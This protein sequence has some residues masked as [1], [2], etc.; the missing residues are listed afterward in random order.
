M[1]RKPLN[2]N[3]LRNRCYD[4]VREDGNDFSDYEGYSG[5]GM[6]G[7]HSLFA[8]TTNVDPRSKLGLK[9]QKLGLTYDNMGFDYVYYTRQTQ[10]AA[11]EARV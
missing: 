3:K 9:L 1:T 2:V 7:M 11:A 10:E 5:R 6:Y 8:F 4:L